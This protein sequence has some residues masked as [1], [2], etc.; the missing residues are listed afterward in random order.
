M[1]DKRKFYINGSWIEPHVKNDF[2]VI[3]PSNEQSYSVISLGSKKDVDLAVDAAK[4]AFLTWSQVD[5]RK[6]LFY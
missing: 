1:L 4:E 6:K 5:K 2:E 3:N